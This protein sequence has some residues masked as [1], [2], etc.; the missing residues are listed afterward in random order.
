MLARLGKY[1]ETTDKLRKMLKSAMTYPVIVIS[2][3]IGVIGIMLGFVI[4]KFEEMLKGTGQELPGPTLF[5]MNLSHFIT[6]NF[7][8]IL[9]VGVTGGFLLFRFVQT[10]EG[11]ATIDQ[12][13]FKIPIFGELARRAGTARFART[14]STL[15]GSGVNLIEAIEICKATIDNSVL[16]DAV[17]KIRAEV[18]SGKTLGVVLHRLNVFPRMAVQMISVGEATGALDKMLEKVADFY[19]EEV[20]AFVGTIGKLIEPIMLVF[21]GGTVA[22]LMIAMYLPIFKA[23]GGD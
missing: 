5:V 18:E 15:L 13:S 4:P 20:E 14:L 6:N 12:I 9:G 10:K 16:E 22:G 19:E 1:L 11:K 8:T 21:L 23:A 2:I 3:S 7:M 17:G